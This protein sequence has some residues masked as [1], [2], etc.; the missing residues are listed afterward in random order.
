MVASRK[1]IVMGSMSEKSQDVFPS[2]GG[3]SSATPSLGYGSQ[4]T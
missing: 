4:G 1:S 3:S 2:F